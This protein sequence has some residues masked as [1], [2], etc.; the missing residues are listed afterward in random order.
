VARR[1]RKGWGGEVGVLLFLI[2]LN[3]PTQ[4]PKSTHTDG[5]QTDKHSHT[6]KSLAYE[7]ADDIMLVK[8]GKQCSKQWVQG[9]QCTAENPY[10]PEI[11]V[12]NL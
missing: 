9:K 7:P 6:P 8:T 5:R 11:I 10:D 12:K 2:W 4:K 1:G 3:G